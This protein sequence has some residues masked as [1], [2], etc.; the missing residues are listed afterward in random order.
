MTEGTRRRLST[1]LLGG[2]ILA[3]GLFVWFLLRRG[4]SSQLRLGGFAYA[5]WTIL[6]GLIRW[7]DL[8][9]SAS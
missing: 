1:W 2:L 9:G 4:Y 6:G 7:I 5:A 3:P 8:I